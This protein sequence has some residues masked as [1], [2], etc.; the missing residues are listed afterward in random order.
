MYPPSKLMLACVGLDKINCFSELSDYKQGDLTSELGV[1][2][3]T[4]THI[5]TGASAFCNS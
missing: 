5:Y 2:T 3:H 4:H 1:Y